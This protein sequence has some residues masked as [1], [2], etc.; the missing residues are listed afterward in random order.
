MSKRETLPVALT[1]TERWFYSLP[2]IG[3]AV[4]NVWNALVASGWLV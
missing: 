1:R 4:P 2:L 3:A